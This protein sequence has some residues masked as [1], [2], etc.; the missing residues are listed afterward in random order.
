MKHVEGRL[1]GPKNLSIYY[2]S[3]QP[4]QD[5]R[6]VFVLV[7]GA[8]EHGGRYARFAPRLAERGYVVIA[9]DL[10]GHGQSEGTPGFVDAFDDHVETVDRIRSRA[11]EEFSGLPQ[12]LFGHSMGGLVSANYLLRN[13]A[14]FDGCVLSGPAIKTDIQPGVLQL[15]MIRFLSLLMPKAGVL[16]LDAKGVSRDPAEVERYIADPH[17]YTGKLSARLVS[18][19]FKAMANVQANASK[20]TLPL[21]LLHGGADS[22]ASPEGSRFLD[23]NV[24]SANKTL[25]IYPELFHEILNEPEREQVTAD[26]LDWCDARLAESP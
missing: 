21:L 1:E 6:A 25:Q 16:Q 12:I 14:A 5:A 7:H 4:D 10:P 8:S 11:A 18:E 22:M 3:W 19:L 15:A 23:A 17:V 26:I 20:I 9:P 2:Q 13:Q 24:G